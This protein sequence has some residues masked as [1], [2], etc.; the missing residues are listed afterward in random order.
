[1]PLGN[2]KVSSGGRMT[3]FTACLGI[4]RLETHRGQYFLLLYAPQWCFFIRMPSDTSYFIRCH[5]HPCMRRRLFVF[6]F[7]PPLC[8]DV[9]SAQ[10]DR[11][12]CGRPRGAEHRGASVRPRPHPP[13]TPLLNNR[14]PTVDTWQVATQHNAGEMNISYQSCAITATLLPV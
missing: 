9:I 7:P 11:S 1:M 6:F 14:C 13:H 4:L 2:S 12:R 3:L 8:Q 5:L 10:A